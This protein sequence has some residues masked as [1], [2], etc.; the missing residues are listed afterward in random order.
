MLFEEVLAAPNNKGFMV[1]PDEQLTYGELSLYVTDYRKK[2]NYLE[3]QS[4][5]L[6]CRSSW[7]LSILALCLEGFVASILLVPQHISSEVLDTFEK[8]MNSGY[9]VL[10]TQL[11]PIQNASGTLLKATLE[12]VDQTTWALA[13]SGT[14]GTPKLWQHT[15]AQLIDKVLKSKQ[16]MPSMNWGLTYGLER[17][18]GLQVYFTALF[19]HGQILFPTSSSEVRS[20]LSFF[21]LHECHAI[22]ATPTWWRQALMTTEVESLQVTQITLGGEIADQA[23]LTSLSDRFTQAKIIHIY[24]STE[25]GALFAV[26]DKKEGFPLSFLEKYKLKINEETRH[27]MVKRNNEFFDTGDVVEV[28][29]ERIIFLGRGNGSINVGGNKVMPEEVEKVILGFPG[30]QDCLVK[31]KKNPFTGNILQAYI[32]YKGDYSEEEIQGELSEYCKERLNEYKVPAIF[33]FSNNMSMNQNLK[34][35]RI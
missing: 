23:L 30:I 17:F 21:S 27:L 29:G 33:R 28:K 6:M 32:Q 9:R 5:T 7:E 1:S 34:R 24:A 25:V 13:T 20:A 16:N 22:S 12:K 18:A 31:G 4:V 15:T 3:G 19:S 35:S 26:K 8:K 2:Y 14:T 10:S 11:D